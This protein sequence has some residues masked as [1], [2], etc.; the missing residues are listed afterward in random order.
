MTGL[1]PF[2]RPLERIRANLRCR[3]YRTRTISSVGQQLLPASLSTPRLA[4]GL[5]RL[6]H[7]CK[8][9]E[10]SADVSRHYDDGAE[11]GADHET[12]RTS[13]KFRI[14]HTITRS[15]DSSGGL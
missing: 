10:V 3:V 9:D 11:D 15:H 6:V 1:W 4:G 12:D 8:F 14:V 2:M 7:V 13:L 5:K